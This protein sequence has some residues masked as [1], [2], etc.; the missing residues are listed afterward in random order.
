MIKNNKFKVIISSL[1]TL[2]PILIGLI[3]WNKL[4]DNMITHWGADG[5]ADGL[6]TKA[7]AIFHCQPFC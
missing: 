2:S 3:L 4:P 6:S 1:L 5:N 7:F